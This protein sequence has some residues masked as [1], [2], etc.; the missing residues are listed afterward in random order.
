[1]AEADTVKWHAL[2]VEECLS[3]LKTKRA[4]L[5]QKEA[6]IRIETYGSNEIIEKPRKSDL[7]LFLGQFKSFLILILIIAALIS[8]ALGEVIDAAVISAIVVLNAAFGFAQIKKAEEAIAALRKLAAPNVKVMRDGKAHSLSSKFLVPGDVIILHVGDKVPADCRILKQMN[9]KIDESILTGESVSV[10]K[11]EQRVKSDAQIYNRT[12][13][14]FSGTTVVYGQC[15]AVVVLTGMSSEFGKIAETLQQPEEETP[16]QKR[17][18]AL[19]KQMGIVFV[20][21]CIVIFL[22]GLSDKIPLITMFVTA[23]SLAVAAVPEGLLAVMTIALAVGVTRMAKRN[24]IV[25]R[26]TAVEGLGSVDVICS[27][28]TGTLTV[29]EMTVRKIWTLNREIDVTGEGYGP[30]G[31]LLLEGKVLAKNEIA[32]MKDVAKLLKTGLLCNDVLSGGEFIGDPTEIALIVSA[33]KAGLREIKSQL[34]RLGEIPFDSERK[35]MS[36]LYDTKDEDRTSVWTK[37][38]VEE[39]LKRCGYVLKDGK[40]R[41]ISPQDRRQILKANSEYATKSFR[42]LAFA[43]KRIAKDGRL[44]EDGLVFLGL[45]A[46]IDP[47]RSEA[48]K[49]IEQCKAAGIRVIMITGDHRETAVAIAKDLDL[50]DDG[51]AITGEELDRL[52]DNEFERQIERI[53]VYARVSPQH[54]VRITDMLRHKGHVVAM[55]GDGIND[56]P[57]LRK[58]DIGVA[59]GRTGTDVTREVADIVLVDDNFATIV[60]AVSEGRGIYENIRKT[61]AFLLS[62]NTGEVLIL[63]VAILIGLPLPLVAIQILWINLVTDGLP[64]IALSIDPIDEDVMKRKARHKNE[65]LT[66]RMGP[67]LVG[68][69]LIMAIAVLVLFISALNSGKELVRAQTMAFT[70]VILFELFVSFGCKSLEKSVLPGLFNNKY[71]FLTVSASLAL[72]FVILYTNQLDI[73]FDVVPLTIDEWAEALGVGVLGFAYLEIVKGIQKDKGSVRISRNKSSR[74]NRGKWIDRD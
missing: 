52:S 33:K 26:L 55:T 38:A 10:P 3:K 67:Y 74:S 29:D 45:Q 61:I 47:P 17:T 59:M 9:L 44:K 7:Q 8:A 24:A 64:A 70:A 57:A 12:N 28:K 14:V 30:S 68:V 13:M 69:P 22:L 60:F 71:L 21:A 63:L 48:K 49:A 73:L 6:D 40:E 46:M 56:A 18:D 39:V 31:E 58:A 16:L 51:K 65:R 35:M 50:L 5:S 43:H 20:G 11:N 19:G 62:C 1:M 23:V 4:G 37:G 66:D 34:H 41:R 42:I 53:S 25:K 2:S 36:V 72:H 32:K 54:K 15:E 27:D